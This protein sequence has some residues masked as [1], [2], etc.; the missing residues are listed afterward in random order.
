[1]LHDP[2]AAWTK[3]AIFSLVLTIKGDED[4]IGND[5]MSSALND[6]EAFNL[7]LSYFE[8]QE[9]EED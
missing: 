6:N 3:L 7:M 2:E 1:M 5:W 9:I 4:Y 8:C